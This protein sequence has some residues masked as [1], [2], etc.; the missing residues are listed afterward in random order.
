MSQTQ[1]N[2]DESLAKIEVRLSELEKRLDK[3]RIDKFFELA[4]RFALPL[5]IAIGSIAFSLH[6]RVTYL[7]TTGFSKYEYQNDMA[8]IKMQIGQLKN[9]DPY[10][11]DSFTKMDTKLD[12]LRDNLDK[13]KERVIK[14]EGTK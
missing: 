6:N 14:L 13:I 5:I 1:R 7:E 8:E 11:R 2:I 12:A 3:S 9:T 10:V 4:T